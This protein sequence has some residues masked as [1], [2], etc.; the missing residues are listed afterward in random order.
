ML[1]KRRAPSIISPLR[2]GSEKGAQIDLSITEKW[3]ETFLSTT[4]FIHGAVDEEFLFASGK[5]ADQQRQRTTPGKFQ[6]PQIL[7]N[8]EHVPLSR[9]YLA[10]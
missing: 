3:A 9:V 10:G 4:G 8:S 6:R 5:A 7:G 2:K 1:L